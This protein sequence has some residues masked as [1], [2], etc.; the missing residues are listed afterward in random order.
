MPDRISRKKMRSLRRAHETMPG[1]ARAVFDR[2]RF[3]NLAYGEIAG[4]LGIDIA[5]VERRMAQ[6]MLH[7]MRNT[8]EARPG[9]LERIGAWLRAA[10]G[11]VWRG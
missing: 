1:P 6:A 11:R 3:R 10:F 7:L 9:G 5:E 4:E 2:H 8:D